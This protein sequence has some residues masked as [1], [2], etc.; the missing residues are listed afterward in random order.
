[1]PYILNTPQQQ[2]K[3]LED[4]GCGSIDE[5]YQSVPS[6]IRLKGPLNVKS[7][8]A[9]EALK[10]KVV[11]LAAKNTPRAELNS[12]LGSGSYD[13]FIPA[14]LKHILGRSEFYT[15]YTPYQ[16]EISQ[17][18]LQAIYEYQSYICL[19]TGM[20]V[21][22]AS[23]YDG[24]SAFC[25]AVLMGFRI[26]KKTKV[27]VTT[28]IHPEYRETL[29]TYLEGEDFTIEEVSCAE[30]GGV[31]LDELKKK[32]DNETC[33]VAFANPN[34][35]G[36][37][38]NSDAIISLAKEKG[39]LTVCI[40]NPF[41]LALLKAPGEAGV[42]IVCGEGGVLG[43]QLNFGGPGFGYLAVPSA[44]V[45]Q[46][47][48]RI[49]GKTTDAQGNDGFCLTLQAREQHI[50]RER[51]TSNICS[52]HSLNAMGAAIYLSLLGETNFRNFALYSLNMTAYLRERL[53][54]IKGVRF[55]YSGP[56]F[57]EFVW[58]IDNAQ[59]LYKRLLDKKIICGLP[60]NDYYP[61]LA[62]CIVSCCTERKTK[63]E[64]DAFIAELEE[65]VTGG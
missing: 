7:G 44:Y 14:A 60:L 54:R 46:V 6:A 29:A 19:L 25:E 53:S 56:T 5:L 63:E 57:N 47:S 40:S 58:E 18:I 26:C 1:M 13:H 50:R 28:T 10:K 24:A 37:I 51:A 48:G 3:M 11:A 21:T 31:C 42:D 65:E 15:A 23:L 38:E 59:S 52:N 4:I 41:A 36:V 30:S 62:N 49:V 2:R 39:I 34:F 12:F 55:P 43:S 35:L 22:N 32:I 45:R 64:I 61:H 27:I 16:A 9:E 8:L 17:G 20:E 33:L